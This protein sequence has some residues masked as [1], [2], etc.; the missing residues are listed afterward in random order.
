MSSPR[1]VC[2]AAAGQGSS[3]PRSRLAHRI[4]TVL[5]FA[6]PERRAASLIHPGQPA[7]ADQERAQSFWLLGPG[8]DVNHDGQ[9]GTAAH[10]IDEAVN[11][12]GRSLEDRLGPAVGKVAHPPAHTMLK[13]PSPAGV[14][15]VDALDPAG[16]DHPITDHKQTLRGDRAA[17]APA[18]PVVSSSRSSI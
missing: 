13:R 12:V 15:E 7:S 17:G 14:A 2:T 4:R 5:A 3:R 11:A 18:S 6:E 9:V 16:D 10:P 8:R 1:S